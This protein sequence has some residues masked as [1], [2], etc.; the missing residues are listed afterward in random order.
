MGHRILSS[1]CSLGSGDGSVDEE[2]GSEWYRLRPG[3]VSGS[4]SS[5]GDTSGTPGVGLRAWFSW[6]GGCCS[7]LTSSFSMRIG[8][9]TVESNEESAVGWPEELEE[10]SWFE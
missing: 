3:E 9:D 7:I 1:S 6:K 5:I 10:G 2:D 4:E 8:S